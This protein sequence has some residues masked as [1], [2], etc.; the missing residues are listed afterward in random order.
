MLRTIADPADCEMCSVLRFLSKK[1]VKPVEIHLQLVEI[2]RENVMNEE[3]RRKEYGRTNVHD[4]TCWGSL[5][6]S[7]MV[8]L[9]K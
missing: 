2:Y 7:K 8:W 9:G 6:L 4:K 3:L 5:L 1:N